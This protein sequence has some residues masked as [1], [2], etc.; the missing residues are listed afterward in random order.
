MRI[1]FVH[2][3]IMPWW[4][5]AVLKDLIAQEQAHHHIHGKIFTLVS[6]VDTL[7]TTHGELR[8]E[9]ALPR[10]LNQLFLFCSKHRVPFLSSLLDYRNLMV[11]YPWLMKILSKKIRRWYPD[12]MIISSFAVAKNVTPISGVPMYLYLHSPM[13]YIWS[14]YEEYLHK[15]GWWKRWLFAH[16]TPRLRKRD[17]RYTKFDKVYANSEYTARLAQELYGMHAEISY[18][19]ISET[20]ADA[21]LVE[22]PLSYYVYVGRLV[23]FVREA[24]T[25]IKLFN[26]L[27]LPLMVM[28]SGPDEAYL[29]SIA[30]PNIVFVGWISDEQEKIKIIGQAKWLV[31]LTKESFGINTAE[32]LLLWVPVFG[33]DD[34]AT[35]GLVDEHSGLLVTN[36]K[37]NTL[38]EAFHT[39]DE[40]QWNRK[41]IAVHARRKFFRK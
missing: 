14:H 39:F 17:L 33:L 40:Q 12:H 6:D 5:L 3:W 38:I 11:F 22:T 4:A 9:T 41:Q 30:H 36:K 13:Q 35:P 37:M 27:K 18:P 7:P 32:A 34:G 20:F 16:I 25:I 29:K 8:I 28:G 15:L 1:A 10:W 2:C 31:N 19:H 24:G 23:Q 26:H 21:P